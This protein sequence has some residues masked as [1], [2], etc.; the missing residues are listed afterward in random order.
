MGL[1]EHKSCLKCHKTSRMQVF[2]TT[3]V[4]CTACREKIMN[5][6]LDIAEELK[7]AMRKPIG[8]HGRSHD[9]AVSELDTIT[10]RLITAIE[11][12][13]KEKQC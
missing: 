11:E 9:H 7:V 10:R 8:C 5:K 3:E 1:V 4:F 12:L 2:P 6:I 13:K